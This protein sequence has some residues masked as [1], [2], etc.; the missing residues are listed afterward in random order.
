MEIQLDHTKERKKFIFF[1][2]CKLKPEV[3][4]EQHAVIAN[5]FSAETKMS[6]STDET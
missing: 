6:F 4:Q 1:G 5:A 3:G 2:V